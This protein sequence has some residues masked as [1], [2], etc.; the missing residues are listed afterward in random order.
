[1][2]ELPDS[3]LETIVSE[4]GR[5]APSYAKVLIKIM[6]D[7]QRRRTRSQVLLG[8]EGFITIRSLLKIAGREPMGYQELAEAAY[9]VLG[10]SLRTEDEREIIR[11]VI[12][13]NCRSSKLDMVSY[14]NSYHKT[15]VPS[16]FA[17][18]IS[19]NQNM[20]R[21]F[22]LLDL[23]IKSNEPVIL[24]GET[25]C[26]KTT[27]CSVISEYYERS[28]RTVN[29]HLHTEA[30]DFLGGLRPIRG[31]AALQAKAAELLNL[32]LEMPLTQMIQHYHDLDMATEELDEIMTRLATFF[33]WANGPL[34]EAMI[35]GD[36]FLIDEISLA[37]ES[38]LERLNSVLEPS[39]Q[40]LLSEKGGLCS[41]T[42]TA[43]DSFKI[44]A[45]MNPGGDYGK[46]ELSL[47]MKNRFTE[48][49]V[50]LCP[51][52]ISQLI[53]QRVTPQLAAKMNEF[54]NWY[55]KQYSLRDVVI[56]CEFIQSQL[57]SLGEE[58][59]YYQG[60]GLVFLDACD[61]D[62]KNSAAKFFEESQ[63]ISEFIEL[64][65]VDDDQQIG[66]PPFFLEKLSPCQLAY[67]FSSATVLD[68]LFRLLRALQTSKPIMLEGAPG[69]GKTSIVESLAAYT[70]RQIT[71]INLS[72]ET[73]LI[74][75]LGCDLPQ[76]NTYEWVDGVLLGAIRR[77]DWVILDELN[78]CSQ[79]VLEGLNA[80]LDHRQTVF[81]PEI[82]QSITCPATFRL[83]AA[84][85]PSIDG[86][87]RKNLPRSFLNRFTRIHMK[88]MTQEDLI[89]I[90]RDLYPEVKDIE[91]RVAFNSAMQAAFGIKWEF[92]LR[93]ILRWVG[94]ADPET[95]YYFRMRNEVDRNKVTSM[96]KE[97]FGRQ[98]DI[99]HPSVRVTPELITIGRAQ[100][101][102][103]GQKTS[104]MLL[105]SHVPVL[106][107]MLL[108]N[109]PVIL[110][111]DSSTGK[112][113]LV[114]LVSDLTEKVLIEYNLSPGSDLGDLLGSFEQTESG[115]F[116]WVESSLVQAARQG[117]WV[118]LRHANLC[119][120]SVLDRLNSLLEPGGSLLIA[121]RGQVGNADYIITPHE[122]FRVFL[123]Y[124][125]RYGEVSR[126]LRNRCV[127]LSLSQVG[128]YGD[129]TRL[130]GT[131]IS[132]EGYE[133][134]KHLGLATW[135]KWKDL[136]AQIPP[137]VILGDLAPPEQL[138]YP[139]IV[140]FSEHLNAPLQTMNDAWEALLDLYSRPKEMLLAFLEDS[141]LADCENRSLIVNWESFP[142]MYSLFKVS[143]DLYYQ[144]LNPKVR[145][146]IAE[147]HYYL[148]CAVE[149]RHQTRTYG[150]VEWQCLY[151]TSG[152]V[153]Q[154]LR[155]TH[156]TN[157]EVWKR[158]ARQMTGIQWITYESQTLP[159][160][161][162]PW[163]SFNDEYGSKVSLPLVNSK[164]AYALCQQLDGADIVRPF[165]ARTAKSL[166][167]QV[168]QGDFSALRKLAIAPYLPPQYKALVDL[169]A[170]ESPTCTKSI[171]YGTFLLLSDNNI[172]DYN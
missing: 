85:N 145:V 106:E 123:T 144:S 62:L 78:L 16:L 172:P 37:D 135:A 92:N 132:R 68:N 150:E 30:S 29:C 39:R 49:W 139:A 47:A 3:E 79:A 125:P 89:T 87:G 155:G 163:V 90:A 27:I 10:E 129:Y 19:W 114:R 105:P 82:G 42:I 107:Q 73:D 169:W 33:E 7:L 14:Y 101:P 113:S 34:I 133:T 38:V 77:G 152:F 46:K 60:A 32:P 165:L 126:A 67:S 69:V 143:D 76:E 161:T 57:E 81:I 61:E 140:P 18:K 112:R 40:L 120:A 136:R 72:E 138:K 48:I 146:D 142:R 118:L 167:T 11:S 99:Q 137:Q 156:N 124:N 116:A 160:D 102:N 63:N 44:L 166:V 91:Q 127:E 12:E 80:I 88:T 104:M 31:R 65:V 56:W 109:H 2:E 71:R 70:G 26:G 131:M 94:G 157:A 119:L 147:K 25:G 86:S 8:R 148:A 6:K 17:S 108:T 55:P 115:E 66:I 168:L 22:T 13:S 170:V 171:V 74:D 45:T 121:E 23:C 28:M 59:A 64:S 164:D 58:Q 41:E 141:C 162:R 154:R 1:M 51:S 128:T 21:L 4:K 5:I 110:T 153:Q 97:I 36:V 15:H 95:L 20:K 96:F 151:T 122:G 75:L 35:E 130:S 50:E 54:L 134:V 103:N 100:I 93:D 149:D 24:V 159:A 158:R 111:G 53:E 98:M 52:D 9:M 117:H 83:F 84:Q 43:A